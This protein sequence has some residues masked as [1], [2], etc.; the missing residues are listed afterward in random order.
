LSNSVTEQSPTRK[1]G[2]HGM[3]V[4]LTSGAPPGIALACLLPVL[5]QIQEALAKNPE[6]SFLV[7]FISTAA[8]L[9]TI[10]GAPLGGYLA[11]RIGRKP[12]LVGAMTLFALF[13]MSGYFL[14]DLYALI[15]VRF[16]V[17]IAASAAVSAGVTLIGDYFEGD[18]RNRLMGLN[19]AIA[20]VLGGLSMPISA[21]IGENSWRMSFLIHGF[22][23][24]LAVLALGLKPTPFA[25]P[26]RSAAAQAESLAREPFPY[27]LVAFSV[28]T[29]TVVLSSMVFV[30]FR[31]RELGMDG[32]T[33]VSIALTGSVVTNI[34]SS[35]TYG[36]VR[37]YTT[38]EQGYMLT[39]TLCALGAFIMAMTPVYWGMVV[40]TMTF[41]LGMGG[42][43][44]A[45]LSAA[46]GSVSTER[47]GRVVGAV[48]G[49][50]LS[51]SFVAVLVYEPFSKIWGA[52]ASYLAICSFSTIMLIFCVI[53]FGVIKKTRLEP[54]A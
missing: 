35:S 48:K 6:D 18:L 19:V 28:A 50:F 45:L 7:K 8:G 27:G 13:G 32:A 9:A 31:V 43:A 49:A 14:N 38:A 33:F 51:G 2:W 30:P 25:R 42:I 52:W 36:Y 41:G 29:G 15:S 5:P 47:R 40:G 4:L 23:L 16:M 22:T 24:I 46:A 17:G 20:T 10:I 53:R 34:L 39:F 3:F 12:V 37:R 1:V 54:A 26:V 44:P 11:D 21:F